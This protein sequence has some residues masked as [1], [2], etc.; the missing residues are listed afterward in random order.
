MSSTELKGKVRGPAIGM[1][2]GAVL[3]IV[4]AVC[5]LVA[6]LVW[7][8][9]EMGVDLPNGNPAERTLFYVVMLVTFA[10]MLLVPLGVLVGAVSL[11]RMKSYSI[12]MAGAI[13]ALMPCGP[14]CVINLPF[15]IWAL[16][17]LNDVNVRTAFP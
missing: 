15:G 3:S 13:L 1:L 14:C 12:A 11:L 2:V 9:E 8:L 16:L 6:S 17:V 10:F 7:G 4:Y 5:N